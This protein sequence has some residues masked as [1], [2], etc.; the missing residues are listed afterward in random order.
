MG[1]GI[2]VSGRLQPEGQVIKRAD[3]E[4][5]PT[6]PGWRGAARVVQD[7]DGNRELIVNLNLPEPLTGS[8]QVWLLDTKAET[9]SSMGFLRP[10]GSGRWPIPQWIDLAQYPVVD[11][12]EEPAFDRDVAHSSEFDRPRQ[13]QLRT[14]SRTRPPW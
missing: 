12:S 1:V 4:A 13:P 11:V 9:M 7:D 14:V 3:L 6:W 5:L 10:D 2:G 8:R